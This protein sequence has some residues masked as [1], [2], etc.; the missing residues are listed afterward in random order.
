MHQVRMLLD[1]LHDILEAGATEINAGGGPLHNMDKVC[2]LA[3]IA[4]KYNE[5]TMAVC[6]SHTYDIS[7]YDK[8]PDWHRHDM[9][10]EEMHYH[11]PP[12]MEGSVFAGQH[13]P[14]YSHQGTVKVQP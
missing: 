6:H 11:H 9:S 4:A 12:R 5:L 3:A 2:Q 1:N 7:E 10:P 14:G 8:C 13:N